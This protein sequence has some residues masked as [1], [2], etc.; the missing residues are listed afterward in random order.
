ML[1]KELI[2]LRE[3]LDTA[4]SAALY[5]SLN[6]RRYALGS[7][8]CSKYT[9]LYLYKSV[10]DSW[11][12]RVTGSIDGLNNYISEDQFNTLVSNIRI[13]LNKQISEGIK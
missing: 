12:Q 2:E 1:L 10:L 3:Q 4:L 5:S 11:T 7:C 6:R 9:M 13:L 8:T